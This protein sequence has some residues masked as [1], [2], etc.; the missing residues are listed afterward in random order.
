M[1]GPQVNH[2]NS[3]P[4][5]CLCSAVGR[6]TSFSRLPTFG[7]VEVDRRWTGRGLDVD[8]RWTGGGWEVDGGWTGNEPDEQSQMQHKS[9]QCS[10]SNV[11]HPLAV[12]PGPHLTTGGGGGVGTPARDFRPTRQPGF[13]LPP[14]QGGGGVKPTHPPTHQTN[15]TNTRE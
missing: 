13:G 14:P 5:P 10:I 6:I 12:E 11:P 2:V 4:C 3:E 7:G 9:L 1:A 8:R 15:L